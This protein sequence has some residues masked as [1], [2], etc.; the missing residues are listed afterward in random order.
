MSINSLLKMISP[1]GNYSDFVLTTASVCVNGVYWS[2]RVGGHDS[3]QD[4]WRQ[5]VERNGDIQEREAPGAIM[6][7][8]QT[9]WAG[10]DHL[11]TSCCPCLKS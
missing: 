10:W 2:P 11:L 8:L 9:L 3:R 5:E 4:Y 1:F 6:I 7:R